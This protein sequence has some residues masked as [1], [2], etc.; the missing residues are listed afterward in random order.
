MNKIEYLEINFDLAE[1]TAKYHLQQL[2]DLEAVSQA[3]TTYSWHGYTV[4]DGELLGITDM[5][6]VSEGLLPGGYNVTY[7]SDGKMVFSHPFLGTICKMDEG[8]NEGKQ[9]WLNGERAGKSFIIHQLDL[10]RDPNWQSAPLPESPTVVHHGP[11]DYLSDTH[12]FGGVSGAIKPLPDSEGTMTASS[13]DGYDITI[14][15]L[16]MI[17]SGISRICNGSHTGMGDGVVLG[18]GWTATDGYQYGHNAGYILIVYKRGITHY[19]KQ[20]EQ[21]QL[22]KHPGAVALDVWMNAPIGLKNLWVKTW[23]E[24]K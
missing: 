3:E 7:S 8:N 10:K 24:L 2:E 21:Q 17:I 20:I 14:N 12:A 9:L 4:T 23:R 1:E 22:D 16:R 6:V 5:L 13:W 19:Q 15:D 18:D 11:F